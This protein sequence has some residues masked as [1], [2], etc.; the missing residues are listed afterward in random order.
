MKYT[1]WHSN[2]VENMLRVRETL[3]SVFYH[4]TPYVTIFYSLLWFCAI[5]RCQ[6]NATG[7][8]F[9]TFGWFYLLYWPSI[10]KFDKFFTEWRY[11]S[12]VSLTNFLVWLC[13][14]ND[15][16]SKFFFLDLRAGRRHANRLLLLLVRKCCHTGWGHY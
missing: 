13:F 7:R 5:I 10:W 14:L 2:T 11:L 12:K 16:V 1:V 4:W 15:L 3:L 9:Y 6:F 8:L